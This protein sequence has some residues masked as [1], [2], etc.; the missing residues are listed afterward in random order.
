MNASVGTKSYE[1]YLFEYR[2]ENAEWALEIVASSPDEA[3]E[4]LKAISWAKYKGEIFAKITVPTNPVA[5]IIDRIRKSW[6]L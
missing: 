4:R 3:K 5:G 6:N 2:F 1:R